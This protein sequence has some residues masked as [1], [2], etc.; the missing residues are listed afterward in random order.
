MISTRAADARASLWRD[1]EF[2]KLWSAF[3]ISSLG[4]QITLLALPLMAVLVLNA[5]A[6]ETGLLVAARTAGFA[7]PGP[8]LGVWVDRY[9]R[10][11]LML[12][13]NAVSALLIGSIPVL[14]SSGALTMAHLYVISYFAG[15]SS[16]V[17]NLSRQAL[18]PGLVGRDRLVAANSRMQGSAAVTQI[19]GPSL[20]GALVQAFTAP[21]AV[22]FDALSFVV[23]FAI[24]A[25]LRVNDVV[26]PR[27]EGSRIWHEM[28]DGFRF[29][30]EQDL[31]F[32]STV[33]I[34]LA[35]IEW[36]AV[37]AVL[38]VYAT[39]ELRLSPALLGVALAASGPSA[40]LGV[41]L[42]APLV[43]RFGMGRVL[44]A[45]LACEAISRLML[46]FIVGPAVT[47]AIL[48]ATTQALIGVTEGLWNVG[49]SSLRQSVTPDR[50]QGRVG[51]AVNS[52]QWIVAPP[53]AIGAGLLGDAI[54]LRPTL[55]L[56]GLI[57]VAACVYLF[58]SP[59]RT[60]RDVPSAATS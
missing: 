34:T 56:Q 3:S 10:K 52:I 49:L 28:I 21:I 32:R 31:L 29:V 54:G 60:M 24:L 59:I 35:N 14:A 42:T 23:S 50:L 43:A 53:A 47:A 37:Q 5:G 30:R 33:A 22:A 58:A 1:P 38:V 26:H 15:V 41:T 25:A 36:F 16:Q 46:P 7:I 6:T 20:G 4:S 9:R 40:L 11:P 12:G 44:I 17:T 13:A 51:S 45:A 39:D 57:A 55:L 2:L 27:L 48:L 18:V 8:L 19:A